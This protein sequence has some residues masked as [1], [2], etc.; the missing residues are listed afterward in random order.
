LGGVRK[1]RKRPPQWEK[2]IIAEM[3]I[4]GPALGC[5][6]KVKASIKPDPRHNNALSMATQP[7][8]MGRHI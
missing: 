2:G 3:F 6:R 8:G 7:S 4:R 1:E 5:D